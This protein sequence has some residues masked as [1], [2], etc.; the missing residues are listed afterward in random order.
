MRLK[1][2]QTVEFKESTGQ[3][4]RALES[5]CAF[6]NTDLG[7]VYF[8][9]KEDGNFK[10][11]EISDR[12][13][14][15]VQQ[16]IFN[17]IEPN[18]YPN[19]FEKYIDGSKILI[20]ELKNAPERPYFLKGRAYKRVGTSNVHLSKSG[21]ELLLYERENPEFNYDRTPASDDEQALNKEKIQWFFSKARA[22]R[23]LPFDYSP[24]AI[25]KLNIYT[26]GKANIAGVLA[27]SD[28]ITHYLPTAF[29]KCAL[30]EGLDKT[31]RILDHQDIKTDVFLQID[32]AENFVL[33]NIRKSAEINPETMR[34]ESKYEVPYR[35]IREAIANAVAHR[36]YQIPSVINVA[37]FDNRI[38][39]WSPGTLPN[40][41]TMN[42]LHRPH[43]SVLRNSTLAELLYLTG[44]IEQWGTGIQNMKD[45]MTLNGLPKP[46]Y[47]QA[48]IHF[49]TVLKRHSASEYEEI[50]SDKTGAG[51]ALSWDQV[52]TKSGLSRDQVKNVLNRCLKPQKLSELI[53]IFGWRNRTKFRDKFVVPLLKNGLLNMTV[54][55][56]P[57]SRNQKYIVSENGK[58]W[59]KENE[60][61]SERGLEK[62]SVKMSAKTSVKIL[63]IIRKD[64]SVSAKKI[65][66]MI[67][68]RVRSVERQLAK[69]KKE[70]KIKRVG[71]AKGGHWEFIEK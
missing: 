64:S 48:G 51:M 4:S 19:I 9:I 33:R 28:N 38:E 11:Q 61:A 30:F 67:G 21:I 10:G 69:M 27:F 71:S 24:T 65:A 68:L 31:G 57:N 63:E 8:G 55:D 58:K 12:T 52:G 42:L 34:R 53:D 6:A 1:E 26:K 3:L 5:L 23:N 22:E 50:I 32:Q 40:G 39:I 36:N 59:M 20:V 37:I 62:A 18:L 41:M 25:E 14:R 35:A 70:G 15:K 16:A 2:S 60:K 44:Y 49:V 45:W 66:E 56:K 17:N 13:F 43:S 54:P 47:K 7:T 46:E 29:V